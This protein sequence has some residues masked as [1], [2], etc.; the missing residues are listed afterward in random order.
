MNKTT[1][2]YSA[3]Q[4][5]G[6]DEDF[7]VEKERQL[8]DTFYAGGSGAVAARDALIKQYL[9]LVLQL[10]LRCARGRIT[11]D[12]AISAGNLALVEALE[13][14]RFD[15]S[16]GTRFS[17]YLGH[18]IRGR[19]SREVRDFP[20]I[21]Q[22]G[23]KFGSHGEAERCGDSDCKPSSERSDDQTVVDESAGQE[24]ELSQL[25]ELLRP[26]FARLTKKELYFVT[27]FYFKGVSLWEAARNMPAR[28]GPT[29]TREMARKIH[30]G[31][32]KKIKFALPDKENPFK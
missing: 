24:V 32:L 9:K 7:T 8:F 16:R 26:G 30:N 17:T 15:I 21:E 5:I 23:P 3:D 14:K 10:S 20:K 28:L 31:A 2:Y 19:V 11:H 22:K 12:E 13:S 25:R 29:I 18:Y 4:D 6:C 1:P 27:Q